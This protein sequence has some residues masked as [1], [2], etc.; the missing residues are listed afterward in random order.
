MKTEKTVNAAFD[1]SARNEIP[2]KGNFFKRHWL[3]LVIVIIVLIAVAIIA[4]VLVHN[5]NMKKGEEYAK[6]LQNRIFV[7]ELSTDRR[8]YKFSDSNLTI[9]DWYDESTAGDAEIISNTYPYRVSV[10]LGGDAYIQVYDEKWSNCRSVELD[11]GGNAWPF[12]FDQELTL[13]QYNK[14]KSIWLCTFHQTLKLTVTEP[15]CTTEG[16]EKS[17]CPQCGW[18]EINTVKAEHTYINGKCTECGHKL[19]ANIAADQ[20][21]TYTSLDLVNVRNALVNSAYATSDGEFISVNYLAVCKHCHVPEPYG[22][23]VRVRIGK[24]YSRTYTCADCVGTTVVEIK[25]SG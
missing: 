8:V 21:Y 4:I 18:E 20:W 22:E 6:T 25:I 15:T 12:M 5:A 10:N 17:Y 23:I 11:E 1:D 3:L 13:S 14:D 7:L 2:K 9:E 16:K 24:D 19:T